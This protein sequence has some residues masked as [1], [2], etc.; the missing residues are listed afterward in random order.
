M[1]LTFGQM[2]YRGSRQLLGVVFVVP[3][4][5]VLLT[6]IVYPLVS[7]FLYSV[8]DRSLGSRRYGA[9]SGLENYYAILESD[10]FLASVLRSLSVTT[11]S[12]FLT[13]LFS[14]AIALLL[15]KTF[16]GRGFARSLVILPWAMPTFVAAFVWRWLV[17]Y[18]YGAFNHMLIQS[19]LTA[20]PVF[21][22][23]RD[24]ALITASLVYTWKGIPWA[25]MVILA[26]LQVYPPELHEAARVDGASA[27][28]EWWSVMLP[29][30]RFVM[31]ITVILSFV[32][33]F[34]WFEMMWLLTQG[35]PGRATTI[36]PIGVYLQAFR[37]FDM[38]AASALGVVMLLLLLVLTLVMFR[39]WSRDEA[40]L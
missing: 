33:N 40:A 11:I 4:F 20:T 29:S 6:T 19:G 32:W 10:D 9:F 14:T 3:S 1:T 21:F 15:H 31:Q 25:T 24:M 23:S 30:L 8:Q 12:V 22:L 2:T 38:G 26:G 39:V 27:W 37:A 13:L 17:D 35:G 34:N 36:L 7:I 5:L 28:R 18:T 16:P